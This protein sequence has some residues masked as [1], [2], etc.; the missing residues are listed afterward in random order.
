MQ[1]LAFDQQTAHESVPDEAHV[2]RFSRGLETTPQTRG[3][4]R[5]GKFSEGLEH[6]PD[7][8]GKRH[9]GRFSDGVEEFPETPAKT[10][11]G[12]FADGQAG[13]SRPR[14]ARVA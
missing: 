4:L 3:K 5:R 9:P 1:H 8:A 10:R 11:R 12:G 14:D 13:P 2:G 6:G 7:T